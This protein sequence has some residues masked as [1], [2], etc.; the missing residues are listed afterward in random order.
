[1]E[2]RN[3]DENEEL[4]DEEQDKEDSGVEGE[5]LSDDKDS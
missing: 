2:E 3:D 1:M 5:E 4:A